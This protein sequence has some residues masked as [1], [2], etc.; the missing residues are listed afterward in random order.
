MPGVNL[1]MAKVIKV[2]INMGLGESGKEKDYL[3]RAMEDLA[4]ITGQKPRLTT[5]R[6]SVAEFRLRKGDPSGLM[7]TLRGKR[8]S[9]FLTRFFK[10]VLP[11]F[12]DFQGLKM[13]GFDRAG[14][15]NLGVA[16]QVVFPEIE[17]SKVDKIR[18]FQITIVSEAASIEEAKAELEKW[19]AM[20]EK[21]KK[22]G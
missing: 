5:A 12:R 1:K 13:R 2:V 19:G 14:N 22:H 9:A 21:E 10:V 18:G 7:V 6:L 11:R 20:F 16:E 3:A 8:M 17:A 15:Y 4:V